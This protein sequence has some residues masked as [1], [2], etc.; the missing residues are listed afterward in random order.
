MKKSLFFGKNKMMYAYIGM[1]FH[2][3]LYSIPQ[4]VSGLEITTQS[5]I[6]ICCATLDSKIDDLTN[7]VIND[8]AGTFSAIANIQCSASPFLESK[9]DD[10]CFTLN[11]KV[12]EL[13][14]CMPTT[15]TTAT[16]I[17][18][19]G[20]YC[21]AN[22]IIGTI[23][24][25]S[26][27]VYLDLNGYTINGSTD[28]AIVI[29][30]SNSLRNITIANGSIIGGTIGIDGSIAPALGHQNIKLQNIS[31]SGCTSNGINLLGTSGNNNNKDIIIE[32]C[33]IYNN[34]TNI[35]LSQCRDIQ[36]LNTNVLASIAANPGI[37]FN[38]CANIL[39]KNSLFN[40][41]GTNGATLTNVTNINIENSFFDEN[42][43]S[44]SGNGISV[45]AGDSITIQNS[46][47]NNN[48][49]HGYNCVSGINMNISF[50]NC[51]FNNDTDGVH[52]D[53]STTEQLVLS[54][55]KASVRGEAYY[56]SGTVNL[57][58]LTNCIAFN[59]EGGFFIGPS[60]T[61]VRLENC[62]AKETNG[63]GS[64]HGFNLLG[65]SII[66]ISCQ[67]LSNQEHGFLITANSINFENC[68]AKNN[69]IGFGSDGAPTTN[70]TLAN[71]I[72]SN[73][74]NSPGIG[75]N[76]F[77]TGSNNTIQSCTATNNTTGFR[78]SGSAQT[79]VSFYLNNASKNTTN[80]DPNPIGSSSNCAP[81]SPIGS[82]IRLY[83]DN[84]E[85]L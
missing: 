48:I 85:A 76:F 77:D 80:Y 16:N 29:D 24:I 37:D 21:L 33:R 26:S 17:T 74:T 9:I 59:S 54:N 84:L 71:C 45:S 15:I 12:S 31:I 30:N 60:C 56:L 62:L 58:A 34:A 78:S 35:S 63:A 36:I 41:N 61:N 27:D 28:S 5:K 40:Q 70:C 46:N 83:G 19:P 64:S 11:S 22:A 47:F 53:V 82:I 6:D 1:F 51:V 4:N 20:H 55:C 65:N 81:I 75:F 69:A 79:D 68:I 25:S 57:G 18:V 66:L 14:L 2:I 43:V 67:A 32:N 39:I 3:S 73:N 38:T 23:T 50:S 42:G 7:I 52:L 44:G 49:D 72:A 13:T 10:C 8:F